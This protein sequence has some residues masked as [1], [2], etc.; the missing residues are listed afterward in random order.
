MQERFDR[1]K[2]RQLLREDEAF[3]GKPLPM[4]PG[5]VRAV[6]ANTRHVVLMLRDT[7]RAKRAS[8]AAAFCGDILDATLA[9]KT[10]GPVACT[11][12]CY[13]CCKTYVGVTIPEIFRVADAVRADAAKTARV[14]EAA[15]ASK[16]LSQTARE[17][18]RVVCPILEHKA[19]S[20]YAP[21]PIVCRA[22]LSSSLPACLRI[23]EG[24]SGEMLP[25]A[26]NTTDIRAY[27][28]IM[29]QAALQLAGLPWMHY[30]MN[31]ALAIALGHRD[32]E[33]RWL[34][35]DPLFEQVPP[36][37]FDKNGGPLTEMTNALVANLAP[38]L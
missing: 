29:L 25:F 27:V 32:A 5:A 19:C 20:V 12:G 13:H 15:A 37:I 9:V 7:A 11:K 17:I 8:A 35:G 26:G 23:F 6:R 24:N 33:E 2:R 28:T 1:A 36:D 21:R 10:Q 18:N 30:E 34:A 38:T 31:Q 4:A 14:H 22:V 16:P 3:I